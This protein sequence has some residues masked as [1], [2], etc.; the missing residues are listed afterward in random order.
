MLK[1]KIL[2]PFFMLSRVYFY[3][4]VLLALERYCKKQGLSPALLLKTNPGFDFGGII[5]GKSRVFE[6][7]LK[8]KSNSRFFA[9]SAFLKASAPAAARL[10]L[11][12]EFMEDNRLPYPVILKPDFGVEGIGLRLVKSRTELRKFIAKIKED[13]I[14]QE[15]IDWP[16]QLGVFFIKEPGQKAGKIWSITEVVPKRKGSKKPKLI[17]P[18]HRFFYKERK[19]L[20]TSRVKK[21][22]SQISDV[23]GFYYGRYDIRVRDLSEFARQGT[24]FKVLEVNVGPHSIPLQALE[25]DNNLKVKHQVIYEG[26][27]TAFRIAE[28]NAGK[29]SPADIE[30]EYKIF[31]KEYRKYLSRLYRKI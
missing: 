12:E 6:V 15:Y 17:T 10:A 28:K 3:A 27:K 5:C 2:K 20:V 26:I 25:K 9:K 31:L 11:A 8:K 22:F 21:I 24:G 16:D 14:I 19:D 7:F 1:N 18:F 29:Y 23:P 4:P 13:Y 30:K